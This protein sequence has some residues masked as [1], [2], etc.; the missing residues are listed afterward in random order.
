MTSQTSTGTAFITGVLVFV[1]LAGYL[2]GLSWVMQNGSF[3]VWG[4]MILLPV[5]LGGTIPLVVRSARREGDSRMVMILGVAVVAKVVVGTL[6]RYAVVSEIYLGSADAQGYHGAGR[7]IA[8]SFRQGSLVVDAGTGGAGTSTINI[9]TGLVYTAIG[10]TKLGGFLVFSWLAFLGLFL[11]YRAYRV[12]LPGHDHRRY[13]LLLFFMPT[14]LFWPSSLGKESW[15]LFTLGISAFGA[16]NILARR[17]RGFPFL[18]LGI[19]G[20]VIVRPHL[21]ALLCAGL[22]VAYLARRAQTESRR[23]RPG[24]VLELVALIVLGVLVAGSFQ[25]FF[26]IEE[27]NPSSVQNL[28]ESTTKRTTQGGGSDYQPVVLADAPYR[29][30]EAAVAVLLR[31]FPFEANNTQALATSFEGVFLLLLLLWSWRSAATGIKLVRRAPYLA[32]ALTFTILFIIGFSSVGNFGIMAR[33]RT[34]VYPFVLAFLTIRPAAAKEEEPLLERHLGASADG[35]A[36]VTGAPS[37]R[38]PKP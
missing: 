23:V 36:G 22:G 27:L 24:K 37:A 26:E 10:P 13:A 9:L 34:L 6:A 4:G 12:A 21:A 33:Q 25:R 1:A 3:D 29:F 32:L 5:L 17:P 14:L 7:L 18:A 8:E 28:L 15:M 16:A 19:L 30:P 35:G 20:M 31:P 11:F 38:V 2:V